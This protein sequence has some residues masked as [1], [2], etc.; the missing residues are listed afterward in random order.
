MYRNT[1]YI[2]IISFGLGVAF[3]SF[4]DLGLSFLALVILI[5]L[6]VALV[7]KKFLLI[8]I[9]LVLFSLGALRMD[10]AGERDF[11]LEN[12]LGREAEITG[13][14]VDEPS[15]RENSTQI[16]LK[17][18]DSSERILITTERTSIFQYGDRISVRGLVR[19]PENFITDND[20]EFDYINYLSKDKIFYRMVFPEI[21]ILETGQG[22]VFRAK[23]FVLK[24]VLISKMNKVI[25]SPESEYLGG[26]IF[27]VKESLGKEL[28]EDFR[29]TGLIHVVVL[30]GYNVTIVA[31]SIQKV[32][33]FLPHYAG[34]SLGVLSII[35][36]AL[37]TG[38]SATIVRASIMAILAIIGG[39]TGR[40]YAITRALF[41]AGILMILHNP[42]ILIFD[43]SFQLSF[44]AT[45]GLIHL[46]PVLAGKLKFL[47]EK[48]QIRELASSTLATQ[49]FVLPL[50]LNKMG[51]MSLIAPVTNLLVLPAVP[52][53]M[54]FGFLT[55][56]FGVAST[57]L[58]TIPGFIS[59]ALLT[60][61][62]K[63]V[64]FFGN[65]PFVTLSIK[66]FPI[67][68]MLLVYLF[69]FY[70]Y[71]RGKSI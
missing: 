42:K 16:V 55:S 52:V 44:L 47:P 61:Q 3:W 37:M 68:L 18:K 14:I 19:A 36:F 22:N 54:F 8:S 17:T 35:G 69:Y 43:P 50:L 23:L 24:K 20:R 5:S 7:D 11:V 1:L 65:L 49:I 34:L 70:L 51:E 64:E 27:G 28:E 56:L 66:T 9:S 63:I 39:A 60:Y 57:A 2:L 38:A 59:F 32:F 41:L 26:L 31:N 45:L 58:S 30:S 48:Y 67:W 12:S 10:F 46:S 25:S 13:I 40:T 21:E 4:F 6:V 71:R 15:K 62:I 53:T 33:A 29:R